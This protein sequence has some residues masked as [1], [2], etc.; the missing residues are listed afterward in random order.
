[1]KQIYHSVTE[2]GGWNA[3]AAAC[4]GRAVRAKL[5]R[6]HVGRTFSHLLGL[7]LLL[8]ALHSRRTFHSPKLFFAAKKCITTILHY[9][10][11]I[12]LISE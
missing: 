11:I 7:V 6:A 3:L 1:M 5:A 2:A 10:S 4:R 9:S 8:Q 12:S